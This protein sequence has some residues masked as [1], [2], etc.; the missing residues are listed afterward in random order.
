M[1]LKLPPGITN[2]A[3]HILVPRPWP[4]VKLFVSEVRASRREYRQI[5]LVRDDGVEKLAQGA[6]PIARHLVGHAV[7]VPQ[8]KQL[9]GDVER[10]EG[11]QPDRVLDR[12]AAP[13]LVG[14]LLHVGG[15]LAHVLRRLRAADDVPLPQDLDLDLVAV[16]HSPSAAAG[17]PAIYR[18][19]LSSSFRIP[20]TCARTS[21]RSWRSP[22]SSARS[23]SIAATRACSASRSFRSAPIASTACFTDFSSCSTRSDRFSTITRP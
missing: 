4:V 12:A 19:S 15:Q 7:L 2:S 1:R 18:F 23:C 11:Q 10:R 16:G 9:V 6:E 5:S 22:W 20:S 14:A 3:G 17:R 8:P 13:D 21:F